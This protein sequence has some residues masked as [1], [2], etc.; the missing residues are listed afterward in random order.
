MGESAHLATQTFF[1]ISRLVNFTPPSRLWRGS[2]EAGHPPLGLKL[3]RRPPT[4]L[5]ASDGEI[6]SPP[7][8]VIDIDLPIQYRKMANAAPNIR[9]PGAEQIKVDG[10]RGGGSRSLQQRRVSFHLRGD[11]RTQEQP[12]IIREEGNKRS[13]CNISLSDLLLRNTISPH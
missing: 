6:D 1:F 3:H 8:P 11:E 13:R 2:L 9:E 10:R 12:V 4:L 7:P 5:P